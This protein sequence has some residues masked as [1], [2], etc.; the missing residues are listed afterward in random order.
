MLVDE[1][2]ADGV[3]RHRHSGSPAAYA[4]LVRSTRL[5]ASHA[6]LLAFLFLI[7]ARS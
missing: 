3:V 6:A 4:L 2:W 5:D 1:E 7:S